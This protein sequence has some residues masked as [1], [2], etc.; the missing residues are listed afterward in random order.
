MNIALLGTGLMGYPMA[1]KLL[2]SNHSLAVYNR[3][4]QKAEGLKEHGAEIMAS[5]QEAIH[6]AECIIL[7]LAD[8]S[9]I[10]DVFSSCR[11]KDLQN[12]TIIQM[13]TIA[14][15]ESLEVQEF[16]HKR[17]GQ[18][19]ECPVLGSR[20]EAKEGTLILLV[21]GTL[22]QFEQWKD[23]L[24]VFGPQPRYIGDVGKAATCKLA[25]NQLIAAH[26]VS[27]S[28]SLG[29]IKNNNIS[30]EQF[31]EILEQSALYAP[32]FKKK[33]SKWLSEDYSNPNFP[34]KH[35]LKDLNLIKQESEQVKL[36]A[37]VLDAERELFQSV[38]DHGLGEEDYSVVL[39]AVSNTL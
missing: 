15:K 8:Q 17:G 14:S 27:F 22:E 12:K 32:M 36:R 26:A 31:M 9:A 1:E 13:G 37:T 16:I 21:G 38:L 28:L 20:K 30:V 4:F 23:F 5:A 10:L 25:L 6:F 11:E 24:K 35:L 29:L 34:A 7:V 18:Y 3:T 33:L 39:K 19:F 2:Q